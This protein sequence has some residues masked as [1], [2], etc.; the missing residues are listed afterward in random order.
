MVNGWKVATDNIDCV[1]YNFLSLW[2]ED[3]KFDF[4]IGK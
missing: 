2:H 1:K 3:Q 4:I